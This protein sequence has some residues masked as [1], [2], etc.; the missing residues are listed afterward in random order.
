M[1][2]LIWV[3]YGSVGSLK[4]IDRREVKDISWCNHVYARE[5]IITLKNRCL[6]ALTFSTYQQDLI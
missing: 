3:L 2:A 6:S 4:G 5:G 1:F